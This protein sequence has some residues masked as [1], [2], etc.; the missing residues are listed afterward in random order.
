M[1]KQLELAIA[2]IKL[3]GLNPRRYF[4][5]DKLD[6][7]RNSI[8]EYGV[9][10]P[11]IVR[12]KSNKNGLLDSFELIIGERRF[13]ACQELKYKTI[14][15][16]IREDL[17]DE[18]IV[19]IMLVENVQRSALSPVEEAES[20]ESVLK[21]SKITQEVLAKKLGKSQAWLA[22]RLRLLTA[23]DEL[24]DILISRKI[25]SKHVLTLL[26]YVDYPVYQSILDEMVEYLD[27][28]NEI[29]V[30]RLQEKIN[31]IITRYDIDGVLCVSDLPHTYR[32]VEEHFDIVNC[33]KCKKAFKIEQYGEQEL[34][35]IDQECFSGKIKIARDVCE[36]DRIKKS[37]EL[38]E[39][40]LV[41][42][43]DMSYDEYDVLSYG[44]FDKSECKDCEHLRMDES[45][46][47]ICMDKSCFKKK[48]LADTKEKNKAKREEKDKTLVVLDKHIIGKESLIPDDY[49]LI[50]SS[51]CKEF[52]NQS[53]KEGLKPYG[54]VK[55]ADEVDKIVE[56]IPNESLPGALLRIVVIQY[57]GIDYF[58]NKQLKALVPE[59]FK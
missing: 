19:E 30:T 31:E 42:L 40:G 25:T 33:L 8:A 57:I 29:S 4:D 10:E 20:I 53:T 45:K 41:D 28:H 39:K 32:E 21:G 35:C 58:N 24:Q 59:A 1:T 43:S 5:Q 34:F 52:F 3:T 7:L 16:V 56:L 50:I 22:N 18:D 27:E 9:L 13:R 14:P 51:I 49:R 23:P 55:Q 15:A 2:K 46:R 37:E 54:V 48:R 26:P 11:I 38:S 6:E 44:D 17:K 47:E 12:Q 36:K